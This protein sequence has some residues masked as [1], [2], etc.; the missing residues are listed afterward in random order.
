MQHGA[1][2]HLDGVASSRTC[3]FHKFISWCC[4]WYKHL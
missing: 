4:W 1:G 2:M 3:F